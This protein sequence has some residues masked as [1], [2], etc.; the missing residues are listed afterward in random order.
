MYVCELC[1]GSDANM[2]T[3][4]VHGEKFI[5]GLGNYFK[6]TLVTFCIACKCNA[7][8]A[9]TY[10]W[11][12]MTED[13][14]IFIFQFCICQHDWLHAYCPFYDICVVDTCRLLSTEKL[15]LLS[16]SHVCVC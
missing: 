1:M 15:R 14:V 5:Q 13:A 16:C 9:N 11:G 12:Q 3:G 6:S 8:T 7:S 10:V 2:S 4:G